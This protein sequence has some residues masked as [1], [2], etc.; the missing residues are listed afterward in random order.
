MRRLLTNSFII[1][2][3]SSSTFKTYSRKKFDLNLNLDDIPMLERLIPNDETEP[4]TTHDGN[5]TSTEYITLDDSPEEIECITIEEAT[6]EKD[7]TDNTDT[8]EMETTDNDTDRQTTKMFPLHAISYP[9]RNPHLNSSR[10]PFG[11]DNPNYNYNINTKGVGEAFQWPSAPM[12]YCSTE[13][14][15]TASFDPITGP[16]PST[17]SAYC[18]NIMSV[19]DSTSDNLSEFNVSDSQ[20]SVNPLPFVHLV[21]DNQKLRLIPFPKAVA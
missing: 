8:E 11:I 9:E 4:T 5:N 12:L 1:S 18:D 14:K 7:T 2:G 21:D 13:P 17:N 20:Q 10:L 15:V 6:E 16:Y 3:H 19:Y